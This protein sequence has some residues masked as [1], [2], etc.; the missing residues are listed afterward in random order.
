MK[1]IITAL[2]MFLFLNSEAQIICIKCF[3]QKE[4]ISPNATNSLLNGS[5]ENTTCNPG[6]FSQW[7]PASSGY[8][9]NIQNWI[10][11]GG[12]T[13]TYAH[14]DDTNNTVVAKGNIAVYFGNYFCDACTN[15]SSCIIKKDCEVTS[16]PNG[17]PMNPNNGYGGSTGLSLSQ[18]VNG[19]TPGNIYF[20]EFW[21]GGEAD[22][23][24]FPL[25][26]LFGVDIGFGNTMLTCKPTLAGS[27][28]L[29]TRYIIEFKATM[30][31]HT[32]KFTNWGH[33]CT[34]CT[35]LILDDVL[36]YPLS[37]LSPSIKPCL[38]MNSNSN[39]IIDTTICSGE[40]IKVNNRVYS[41]GGNY[42][43][44]MLLS[45]NSKQ[46]FYI[47]LNVIQC[48]FEDRTDT[49][50]C[51]NNSLYWNGKVYSVPGVYAD[52]V[53]MSP[54]HID[55]KSL[56][57]TI[58]PCFTISIPNAFSPNGDQMNDVFRIIAS[59]LNAEQFKMLIFDRW[60]RKLF[61]SDNP[62]K[63]W[64]GTYA[65][66]LC[67]VGTYFYLVTFKVKSSTKTFQYNGNFILMR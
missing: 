62:Q 8:S 58:D 39:T 38:G 59:D 43:D 50:I 14:L 46:Y 24:S 27:S 48:V 61:S 35:E 26:G 31:S 32:I 22:F 21:V 42:I 36:L 19:L 34:A 60:G 55:V 57:L 37:Q 4:T 33:I 3:D 11:T 40:H 45:S 23:S 5:F 53:V 64:N 25:D 20:L 7:C 56:H 47:H 17:F 66:A 9:C 2:L 28:A 44:S 1:F 16:I 54:T 10:A 15:S 13:N 18:T 49:T 65:N 30:P 52:S 6:N 29:G 67:E 63:G 51:E 41:V 12:G